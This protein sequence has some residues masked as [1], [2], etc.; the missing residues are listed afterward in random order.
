MDYLLRNRPDPTEW[1]LLPLVAQHLFQVW[2]R[3]QVDL[4]ASHLNHRLP[5]WLS[6]TG[7]P[8]AAGA[9]LYL[10]TYP[11]IPLLEKTLIKISEDQADKVIVITPS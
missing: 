10:F 8:M 5:C 4:F 7:H 6:R 2:G 11:L 1:H 3:P 9:G